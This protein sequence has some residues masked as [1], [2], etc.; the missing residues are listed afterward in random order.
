MY[1][2]LITMFTTQKLCSQTCKPL[3]LTPFYTSLTQNDVLQYLQQ[4]N[5]DFVNSVD[6]NDNWESLLSLVRTSIRVHSLA[7]EVLTAK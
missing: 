5:K 3:I 1:E 7:H 4:E 6:S 2:T